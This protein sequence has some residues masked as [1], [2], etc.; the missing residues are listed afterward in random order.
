MKTI[1]FVTGNAGKLREVVEILGAN[2]PIVNKKL[3]LEEVQGTVD[4][5]TIK[6]AKAAA[7]ILN[8]PALVEDTSLVFNAYNGLPGPYIKW[9]MESLGNEGL[10]KMLAGFEDKSATAICTFGYCES[11]DSDVILFQGKLDGTIVPKPRGEGNFGWNPIFEPKGYDK[12]F[13]E[14][15]GS[16][17]NSISHR[18]LALMKLKKFL[19]EK[20]ASEN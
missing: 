6:K 9:F 20:M 4:E 2:S 8:G 5:V 19:E 10:I 3:D 17:K 11:P 1:T 18:Y 13:A 16:L 12:T 14:M 7:A 15:S